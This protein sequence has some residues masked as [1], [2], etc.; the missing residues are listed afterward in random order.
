MST[1]EMMCFTG[2]N[3]TEQKL[4][5]LEHWDLIFRMALSRLTLNLTTIFGFLLTR[6]ICVLPG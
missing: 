5:T 6:L 2:T 1:A 4:K 3:F